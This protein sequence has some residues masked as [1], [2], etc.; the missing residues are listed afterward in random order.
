MTC[1]GPQQLMD[2]IYIL[3]ARVLNQVMIHFSLSPQRVAVPSLHAQQLACH[4]QQR[5]LYIIH[6]SPVSLDSTSSQPAGF[7]MGSIWT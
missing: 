1:E 3:P 6:P 7:R 4:R 2:S 5:R